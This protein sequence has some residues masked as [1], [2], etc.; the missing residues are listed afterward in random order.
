MQAELDLEYELRRRMAEP[1]NRLR[2]ALD[3]FN[4]SEHVQEIGSISK[5]LG[6]PQVHVE[7]GD[8]DEPPISLTFNWRD[9]AWR[10][11]AINPGLA[12]QEPRIYLE[13][14]GEDLSGVERKPSNAHVGAGGRVALGL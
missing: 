2:I 1:E 13:S 3:L 6:Q 12:V 10:T 7:V 9:V 4:E 5:S 8:G 14:A 11:Y